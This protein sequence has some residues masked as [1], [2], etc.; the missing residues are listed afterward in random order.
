MKKIFEAVK[1]EVITF[2]EL[3]VIRTSGEGGTGNSYFDNELPIVPF[4]KN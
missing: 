4:S 1:L 2:K 3:D